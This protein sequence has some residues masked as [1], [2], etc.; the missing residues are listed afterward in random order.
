MSGPGYKCPEC[1]K[2]YFSM[3]ALNTHRKAKHDF[4]K[5]GGGRGRGR[6]RK[7]PLIIHPEVDAPQ[8]QEITKN[9]ENIISYS[10]IESKLSHFF[11]EENRKPVYGEII[12][13]KN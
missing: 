9:Q 12:N 10:K 4:L 6:P 1:G 11:D 2:S 13:R 7:E 5:K 8:I 3:P